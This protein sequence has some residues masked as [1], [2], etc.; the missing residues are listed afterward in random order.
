[1]PTD[2]EF[3][4]LKREVEELKRMVPNL[5]DTAGRRVFA[6]CQLTTAERDAITSPIEGMVIRNSTTGTTQEYKS[7]S[8]QDLGGGVK[9]ATG[10]YT[11][12]GVAT[13]AITVGFTPKQVLLYETNS[14]KS[15]AITT[16]TAGGVARLGGT[17]VTSTSFKLVTNGFQVEQYYTNVNGT[18]YVWVAIG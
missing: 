7:G 10:S 16:S 6:F 4:A 12:D 2:A 9:I 17:N 5:V 15:M 3:A 13:R 18:T 11:G 14:Y 1:M 8:W